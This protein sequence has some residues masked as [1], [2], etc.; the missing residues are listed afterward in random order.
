[1]PSGCWRLLALP[2]AAGIYVVAPFLVPVLLG[3]KWLDA[4]PLM[5]ILAF[6]GALL[7]FHSSI[8]AVLVGRGFPGRVTFINACYTIMLLA[9]LALFFLYW[10]DVGVIGAAY[11]ALLTSL[12]CTPLYIDQIRRCLGLAPSL[13]L[14]AIARPLLATGVMVLAVRWLLPAHD[15][16]IEFLVAL[17]WL[18]AGVVLGMAT[19]VAAAAALWQAA[20]RPR[21]AEQVLLERVRAF[22]VQRFGPPFAADG[23]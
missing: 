17:A 18:T 7:L 19:Y 22:L 21:G 9:L 14:K 6:N 4:I 5:Q 10:R 12:F 15:P 13:F 16:K 11:A 23:P 3:W 8:C 20:G 2:A 1:M